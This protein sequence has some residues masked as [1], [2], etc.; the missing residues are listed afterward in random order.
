MAI[1]K[2]QQKLS[3][4]IPIVLFVVA[5]YITLRVAT[6][7]ADNGGTV[8]LDIISNV[9]NT[10]YKINTPLDLSLKNIGTTLFSGAFV[11]G[12][13]I[14][15][16]ADQKRNKQEDTYGSA[17]YQDPSVLN[18]KREKDI[19]GNI[20]LTETEQISKNSR[21]SHLNR[22]VVLIGRSG[23]GK[24]KSFFEPNILNAT[25]GII[26]TDP[27]GELL[28]DCGH[29]LEE[30]G[31]DIR[32]LNLYDM[33]QSNHYNPF[34]YIRKRYKTIDGDVVD[35]NGNVT[36]Q[37]DDVMSL[38]NTIVK[39]TKSDEIKQTT[40]DP[41]W[42]RAEVLFLQALFYYI[43]EVYPPIH[44]NFGTLMEL[45]RGAS[46]AENNSPNYG[47]SAQ[48]STLDQM[49][50]DFA[51]D[52]PTHI[53]T[54]QWEHFK[55]TEAS[56][57]MMSTIVLCAVGRLS[58]FNIKEVE[59]LVATDD[60]E[61]N[62][63]GMS[64][65]KNKLDN[66]NKQSPVKVKN[67]KI[68]YFIIT[69]PSD[70]TFNFIASM[71]YTQIFQVIDENAEKLGGSLDTP[72]DMFLDEFA[73]M[74][75]IPRFQEIQS[76]VRSLNVGIIVA[77][78]SLSQLKKFYQD[79]W[80]TIIDNSDSILFLGSNS[81]E[82]LEYFVTM[83]GKE[84]LYKKSTGT[85]FGSHGSS[86]RN[87]DIVGRELATID[88]LKNMGIGNCILLI[89][90]IGTFF[91]KTY[92]IQEHPFYPQM[93]DS[94]RKEETSCNKYV[95]NP[96]VQNTNDLSIAEIFSYLGFATVKEIPFP[97]IT[98]PTSDEIR[99]AQNNI[100]SPKELELMIASADSSISSNTN[101]N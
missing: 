35:S 55:L 70:D 41:F 44:Q 48:E 94:W 9:L 15:Y 59:N 4:T 100:I 93:Y 69:K 96:N 8:T 80:E 40:G 97:Q 88:E 57:K 23:T 47:E 18:N 90:N 31:Y 79:T 2:T 3:P 82:T 101:N 67:G 17:K 43:I 33:T 95:H 45:L 75:E 10:I 14:I 46:P 99:V 34:M 1:K 87:W 58:V 11:S 16:K 83:M 7:V 84:T 98:T 61:L 65:D 36:I 6:A 12:L 89:S 30:K 52:H 42:E 32:V 62:R 76:Y 24:S 13:Y 91:S 28:R 92:K 73:Q 72:F 50:A 27:K 68:A 26:C 25:G 78:Q 77:L 85:T 60:M 54:K 39:N 20:I 81:K 37:E 5:A 74:G 71:M 66:F 86:N 22:H 29:V 38:I 49:F 63:I 56:Q 64:C 19:E 21:T 51:K 53:A